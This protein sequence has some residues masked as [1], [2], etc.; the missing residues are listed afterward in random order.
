MAN[1]I[2]TVTHVIGGLKAI[3][4]PDVAIAGILGNMM[5]ESS[6]NPEKKNPGEDAIG[7]CQ[8]EGSRRTALQ[9]FASDRG[10]SETD[11]DTQIAFMVQEAMARGDI[12]GINQTSSPGE[13]ADYWNVH[14][15]VSADSR[16]LSS[17]LAAAR[18]HFAQ[19]ILP[20]VQMAAVDP[21]MIGTI[22]G[23][24]SPLEDIGNAASGAL[25]WTK[26]LGKILSWLS[27]PGNW[28][29]IGGGAL[30][31]ALILLAAIKVTGMEDEAVKLASTAAKAAA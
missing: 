27:T 8:W 3:G 19:Q 28:W 24:T 9:K 26:N 17:D 1:G 11:L 13:A 29:R 31:A 7:L 4:L 16:D 21:G 15:E 14:Y 5:I 2:D 20:T 12:P 30:G 6:L 25:A 23:T 10:T 18:R 22:L